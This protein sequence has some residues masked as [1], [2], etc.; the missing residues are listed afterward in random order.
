MKSLL[1][2][3]LI[4]LIL[5]TIASTSEA[6][7]LI[8]HESELKGQIIDIDTKQPIEGAVVVVV[9]RTATL[10]LGAGQGTSDIDVRETLTDKDGQF[11]IPPYTTVIQPFSWKIPGRVI[12]FKPGYASL[13]RFQGVHPSFFTGEQAVE[14]EGSW[15]DSEFK[16]LKYRLRSHGIVEIPKLETWKQRRA[17]SFVDVGPDVEDKTTILNKLVDEENK[18]LRNKNGG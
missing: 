7:W 12:I 8:Y 13:T 5:S 17:A 9:Y 16:S 3:I 11:L 2:T 18:A 6:G 4:V 1:I 10:G 15:P 14:R